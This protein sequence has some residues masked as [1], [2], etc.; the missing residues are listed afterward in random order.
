MTDGLA[1]SGN[2]VHVNLHILYLLLL[3]IGEKDERRNGQG[4]GGVGVTH[5]GR[6][7]CLLM[8]KFKDELINELMNVMNQEVK[9][10]K[11]GSWGMCRNL[12]TWAG[13]L[14]TGRDG[15]EGGSKQGVKRCN[16]NLIIFSDRE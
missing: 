4:N 1:R 8:K 12:Y 13:H 5:D 14:R 2:I 10:E 11:S 7:D 15:R 6:T 16:V 3:G 9:F